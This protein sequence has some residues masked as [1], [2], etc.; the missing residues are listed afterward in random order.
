MLT[1]N[2]AANLRQ[3]MATSGKVVRSDDV[4]LCV[5]PLFHIMGLNSILNLSLKAGATLV[6]QGVSTR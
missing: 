2:L 5:L 1:R 6:L 4:G 3:N